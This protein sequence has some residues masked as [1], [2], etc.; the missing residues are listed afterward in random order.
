MYLGDSIIEG[1]KILGFDKETIKKVSKEKSLEEIFL[2]TLFLNYLIV[3]VVFLVSLGIGGIQIQG[4][5]LNMPVFFGLLMVYP[6][7]FNV[8]VYLVY[9][10]FGVVAELLNS[11]KKVKPLISVGFHSAIVYTLLFYVIGLLSTYDLMYGLFLLGV[12]GVYFLLTMF[13]SVTTIY[14]FSTPQAMMV[15]LIPLLVIF[16]LLLSAMAFVDLKTIVSL[17]VK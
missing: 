13:L 8:I 6:F 12:F 3:L 1:L 14:K 17:F 15:L 10:L 4:R 16:V 2:S 9:G 11:H 5:D 7:A